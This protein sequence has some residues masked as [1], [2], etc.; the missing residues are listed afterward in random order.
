MAMFSAMILCLSNYDSFP[1]WPLYVFR[2]A[3]DF[4]P[5]QLPTSTRKIAPQDVRLAVD[6]GDKVGQC[7]CQLKLGGPSDGG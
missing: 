7:G 5:F 4:G 2:P 1:L 6:M 3:L